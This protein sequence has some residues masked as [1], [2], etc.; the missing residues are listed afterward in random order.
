MVHI[1]NM[2]IIIMQKLNWKRNENFQSNRIRQLGTPKVLWEDKRT[3][4]QSGP[5]T[6]K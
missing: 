3:D 6:E 2:W 1:F 5:I 4:G